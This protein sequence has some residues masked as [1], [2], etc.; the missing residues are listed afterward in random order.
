METL[1]LD[2]SKESLGRIAT[3]AAVFLMGKHNSLFQK[4]V[5]LPT[6]VIVTGSDELVLTGKKMKQKIY[7]RHS[8]YIGKLKSFSAE[9][10]KEHDSR[11]IVRAAVMGMLPKNKLRKQLI[12]NLIIYKGRPGGK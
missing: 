9:W 7:Y 4:H 12:K 10:M 2:A 5:K 1:T 6:K 11:Q 3:K 8:G